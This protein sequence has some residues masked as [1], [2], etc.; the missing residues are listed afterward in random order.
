MAHVT[1]PAKLNLYLGVSGEVDR[2]GYHRLLTL[3]C[4]LALADEVEV[5][6]REEGGIDLTCAPDPVAE[7]RENLAWKAAERLA[8]MLD[9]P[10]CARIAIEKAIPAQAGLGGGSSDA[11]AVLRGLAEA[12][13]LDAR[14]PRVVQVARGLG[15]DVAFFLYG[16]TCLLGGLGDELLEELTLPSMSVAL[17]R[18]D[19]GVPTSA[20]Y[21]AFD[22]LRTLAP[23]PAPLLDAARA[24]DAAGVRAHLSNNLQPAACVV[25]PQVAR[26]IDFLSRRGEGR[27]LL[28]GSGSCCA[29]F[30][31]DDDAAR[32]VA[33]DAAERGWWSCATRTA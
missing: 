17:V 20:A 29:L 11:A 10:A 5:E 27:P 30:T 26:V 14:D 12:W 28:C 7:P 3:M 21:R 9:R 8:A 24:G 16:G 33:S 25:E 31:A 18:P 1:A 19:A 15:A 2:R 6:A 4:P 23:D 32:A 13:G 22:E